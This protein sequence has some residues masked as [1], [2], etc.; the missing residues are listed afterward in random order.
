MQANPVLWLRMAEACL[1]GYHDLK[2]TPV[3]HPNGN[4]SSGQAVAALIGEVTSE[5]SAK[6]WLKTQAGLTFTALHLVC[7]PCT[8]CVRSCLVGIVELDVSPPS[9]EC[10]P[11]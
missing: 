10:V 8:L 7:L 4:L 9:S 6:S 11:V 5:G 1:G 2:E 3:Q